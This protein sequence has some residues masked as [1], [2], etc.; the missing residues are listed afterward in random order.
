MRQLDEI[1]SFIFHYFKDKTMRTIII[2][3]AIVLFALGCYKVGEI[4]GR[5]IY[6]G[7]VR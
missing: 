2:A 4:F 5:F 7:R 1:K 3:L 6:L